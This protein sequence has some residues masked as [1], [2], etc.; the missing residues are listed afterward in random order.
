MITQKEGLNMESSENSNTRVI[1]SVQRALDIVECFSSQKTELSL[2]EISKMLQLNKSTVHGIINTLLINGYINQNSENGKYLLGKK[3]ISKSLIVPNSY[4]LKSFSE[5]YLEGISEKY[6]VSSHLMIYEKNDIHL[7]NMV[8]PSSSYYIISS[9]FDKKIPFHATASG[10]IILAHMNPTKFNNYIS[11]NPLTKFTSKTITNIY[12][13]QK[14]LEKIIE[15]GCSIEDE[16]V[17][18]GVFSIACPIYNQ[19]H[20]LSATISISANLSVQNYFDELTNDLKDASLK[21]SNE[22]IT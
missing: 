15:N 2:N 4:L 20:E 21:I 6:G 11:R 8:F 7:L 13:L 19:F 18:V 22:F 12:A 16:E 17:E 3:F 1:Q 10:K 9:I 14:E 5:K